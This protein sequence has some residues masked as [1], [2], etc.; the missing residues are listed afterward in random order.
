MTRRLFAV[1]LLPPEPLAAQVEA[2]R[3]ALGDPRRV[4][5]PAH[6]T[7]V[8]P[9]D[10][11]GDR[12]AQLPDVLRSVARGVEPF[13]LHVGPATTFAPRTMTL[14][15][16]ITGDLERLGALRDAL[17]V[18]PL[19]RPD[20]HDFV[21]HV[22][23]LQRARA[24]QIEAGTTLLAEPLGEWHVGSLHLLERLRPD[25]GPIWHAV[26]Q[27]PLGGPDVVG[28]GGV[29]LHLRSI[30]TVE[31]AA[32]EL[33]DAGWNAPLPAGSPTLVVVAELPGAPGAPVGVAVGRAGPDG[34]VLERV[35]VAAAHRREGIA[36]QVV[37][38]WCRAAADR[39]AGVVVGA[40]DEQDDEVAAVAD[41]LGFMAVQ[42]DVWVRRI[43]PLPA[44]GALGSPP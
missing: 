1:A 9:I 33:I 14:H 44:L 29:E 4:D 8:P 34:A 23:L 37:A 36:R 43:G 21:P 16:G 7:L 3:S 18:A 41:A 39:G 20:E 25:S 35:A 6:L 2:L 10:L 40:R 11:D 38:Q 15:L 27:E 19:D 5:L 26:A 12:S 13:T 28:R 42:R 17:R 30:E 22:T 31:P 24:D 32:A